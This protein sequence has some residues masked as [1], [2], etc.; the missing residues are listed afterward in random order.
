[1]RHPIP[2]TSWKRITLPVPGRKQPYFWRWFA[3]AYIAYYWGFYQGRFDV[4]TF[5]VYSG[6]SMKELKDAFETYG[7]EVPRQWGLDSFSGLP[8]EDPTLHG[9]VKFP[10]GALSMER[11][12]PAFGGKRGMTPEQQVNLLMNKYK[13]DHDLVG[14]VAGYYNESLTPGLIQ[15][16]AMKP[17]AFIDIDCDLYISTIQA[18]DWAFANG[19]A[20]VG[21]LIGYDDFCLSDLETDGESRA[22]FEVAKKFKV[23]FKCVAGICDN[24]DEAPGKKRFYDIGKGVKYRLSNPI[25]LVLSVGRVADPGMP[26]YTQACLKESKESIESLRNALN[27]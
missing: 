17:A 7:I 12:M 26:K 10:A 6:K 14:F 13:F 11:L 3:V 16:R 19:I 18:L 27:G 2:T 22:H 5:G 8:D 23:E 9:A 21:T 24:G 15:E 20:T 1:M 4:Y 25:F